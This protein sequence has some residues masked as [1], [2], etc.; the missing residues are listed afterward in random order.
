[1]ELL[2]NEKQ[3]RRMIS[4]LKDVLVRIRGWSN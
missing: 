4:H 2:E 3:L 1:M